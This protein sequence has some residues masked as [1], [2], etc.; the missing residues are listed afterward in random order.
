[1]GQW[2]AN[3]KRCQRLASGTADHPW[4][5]SL[6]FPVEA[7]WLSKLYSFCDNTHLKKVQTSICHLFSDLATVKTDRFQSMEAWSLEHHFMWQWCTHSFALMVHFVG[8]PPTSP[9]MKRKIIYIFFWINENLIQSFKRIR[10]HLLYQNFE[11]GK[12]YQ[13]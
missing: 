13:N 9:V 3:E 5:L 8:P 12:L 2:S 1:M 6:S 11:K 4:C 7:Y 10:Y